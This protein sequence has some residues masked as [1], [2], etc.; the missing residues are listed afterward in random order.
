[1]IIRS[2]YDQVRGPQAPNLWFYDRFCPLR[3]KLVVPAAPF[4]LKLTW[5]MDQEA[6]KFQPSEKSKIGFIPEVQTCWCQYGQMLWNWHTVPLRKRQQFL[7]FVGHPDANRLIFG[8]H[9]N[10]EYRKFGGYLKLLLYSRRNSGTGCSFSTYLSDFSDPVN[11]KLKPELTAVPPG[12][13]LKN[14]LV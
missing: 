2:L 12:Q 1:M 5:I 3:H 14:R 7:I 6:F 8:E 10:F 4:D 13:V 9:S 11:P